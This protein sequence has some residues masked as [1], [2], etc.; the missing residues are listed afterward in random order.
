MPRRPDR[1]PVR[2]TAAVA[3]A[4]LLVVGAPVTANADPPHAG[5]EPARQVEARVPD[6]SWE[7]CG[8][9]LEAFECASA[10]VPIDYDRPRGDTTT[11]ALTRLPATDPAQRIGSLFL[12]FGGPG[13][14]GVATLHQIGDAFLDPSV[15]ERFDI[16]AFDPRGVG[17]SDPVTCFPDA[18]TE[19]EFLA[20]GDAF[21]T[22]RREEARFQAL[23]ATLSAS[24]ALLSGDRIAHAS[25]ANVARDMDLLRQ[26]VGDEQL[27]YLGY[28][29]GTVLGATYGALFPDRV[30]ALALDGTLDPEAWS[31]GEGSIGLR[32]GQ[33]VAASETFD[34]FLRLCAEAGP[35]GCA[36]A[37]L[38]DP[39]QVVEDLF[40]QLDASPVPVPM[41]DGTVV[42][43]GYDDAVALAFSS[44]YSP[45]AWAD[46]AAALAALAAP[47]TLSAHGPPS[48]GELL[49]ELGLIEDYPSIGGALASMCVD[50]EHPLDPWDYAAQAD[51]ADAEAPHFGRFR[52][53]VGLQCEHVPFTDADAYTGPWD[54]G[55][56]APVLVIGTRYDPATPYAFTQP[57]ADRWNDASVLTVEGYGHTTL[58]LSSCATAA[59]AA[60]LVDLE[61]TDGATCAQDVAPFQAAAPQSDDDVARPSWWGHPAGV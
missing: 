8:E 33:G 20:D 58:G 31:G 30:R 12:N 56:D 54:Q 52:S 41:P 51:A 40:A 19:A 42:E 16:V 2:L 18:E 17:L 29:Y 39:R 3:A 28:S 22:D 36:L 6:L 37:A 61:A 32:T 9:G 21:P 47:Q 15:R 49:R 38:G 34:E 48:I 26:A 46:L 10:E 24:C 11:I 43:F 44:L 57:Y 35:E 1:R 7:A 5:A 53:W 4:A 55:T 25:T 59:I 50:G 23:F 13:G 14:P 27:S 45:V 60:Y